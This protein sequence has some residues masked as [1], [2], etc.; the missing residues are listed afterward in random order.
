MKVKIENFKSVKS[1][2]LQLDNVTILLGPPSA[3]KSNI[4]E[5]LALAGYVS[6][7]R[8]KELYGSPK[9]VYPLPREIIRLREFEDLFFFREVHRAIEITTFIDDCSVSHVF[10]LKDGRLTYHIGDH[11]LSEFISIALN[12]VVA[13]SFSQWPSLPL[14]VKLLDARLYGFDRFALSR[15]FYSYLCGENRVQYPSDVLT[16]D[17]RNIGKIMGNYN[18]IYIKVNS[19]LNELGLKIDLRELIN[20][21]RIAVFD[22]YREMNAKLLSDTIGRVLYTVAALISCASYGRKHPVDGKPIILLE[23]PEAHVFPYSFSLIVDTIKEVLGHVYIVITTH[24]GSFVS[25]LWDKIK[26][27]TAYYVYRDEEGATTL[28]KIDMRKL[29]EDLITGSD[30]LF[31]KPSEVLK[32]T[33]TEIDVADVYEHLRK[34]FQKEFKP[35]GDQS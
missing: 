26:H 29:A 17:A 28:R 19:W 35:Y 4:L 6:R 1:V 23:E 8:F 25:Y 20:P 11:D 9:R 32:Y 21:P 2:E 18:R 33:E 22:Y 34:V 7:L 27:V 14:D 5:A 3:G 10:K 24:N 13:S 31:M 16:E 12:P 15:S 30:L